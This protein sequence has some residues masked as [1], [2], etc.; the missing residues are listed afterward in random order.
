MWGASTEAGNAF[1]VSNYPEKLE[2]ELE[3]EPMS[4]VCDHRVA[5]CDRLPHGEVGGL[6]LR[7]R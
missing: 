2:L 1:Y 4:D 7:P 6:V 3:L 5:S